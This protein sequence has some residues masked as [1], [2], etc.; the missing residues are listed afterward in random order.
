MNQH[1]KK[2]GNMRTLKNKL[3]VVFIIFMALFIT[4]P[5]VFAQHPGNEYSRGRRNRTQERQNQSPTN[6]FRRNERRLICQN[7]ILRLINRLQHRHIQR[8]HRRQMVQRQTRRHWMRNHRN[9]HNRNN[10][11]WQRP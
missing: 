9:Y 11:Y 7:W 6:Q 2:R 10:N 4:T 8:L 3:V 1:E 5:T